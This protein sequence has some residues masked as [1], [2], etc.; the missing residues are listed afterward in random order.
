MYIGE[1]DMKLQRIVP[2]VLGIMTLH[3]KEIKPITTYE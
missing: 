2:I 1:L 3:H